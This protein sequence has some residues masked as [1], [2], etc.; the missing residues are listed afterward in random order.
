MISGRK[1]IQKSD[2]YS[3]SSSGKF[4]YTAFISAPLQ[5]PSPLVCSKISLYDGCLGCSTCWALLWVL[6]HAWYL[7]CV[8]SDQPHRVSE[9]LSHY[10]NVDGQDH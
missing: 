2:F 1:K 4:T 10:Y 6:V 8:M 3:L 7:L 9:G 5:Y